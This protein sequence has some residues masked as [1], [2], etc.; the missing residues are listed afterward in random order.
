MAFLPPDDRP[1]NVMKVCNNNHG[2]ADEVGRKKK[3]REN[4]SGR[5]AP[6]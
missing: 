3:V 5:E 6:T 4:I 2:D 1:I